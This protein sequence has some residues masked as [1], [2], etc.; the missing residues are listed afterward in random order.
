[1]NTD[2]EHGAVAI[3][4]VKGFPSLAS[5]IASDRDKT[6]V[7]FKRF[8]MLSARN[9]LYLQSELA[10]LQARQ[11]LFDKEDLNASKAVK[12]CARNWHDFLHQ[13]EENE[14][15]KERMKLVKQIRETIKE[16]RTHCAYP[17][18]RCDC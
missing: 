18:A 13:A 7:I 11:E 16:Y 4:Y 17:S 14:G 10:E 9:L 12:Q 15:Q 6:T 3:R 8:D 5:F 1:M 2:T